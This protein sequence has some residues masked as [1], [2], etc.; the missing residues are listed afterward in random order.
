MRSLQ[1][2]FSDAPELLNRIKM[3]EKPMMATSQ[4]DALIIVTEWKAFR[5]P[6]FDALKQQLKNPIIFDG[7]NLFEPSTL[8]DQGFIYMGIGRHN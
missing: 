6:D 7:R 8:A 5:S 1:L 2:D 3:V 4:A